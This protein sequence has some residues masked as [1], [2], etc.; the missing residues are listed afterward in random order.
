[1]QHQQ[2]P[3]AAG[4]F[5][6]LKPVAEQ[7]CA[8]PGQGLGVNLTINEYGAIIRTH[9]HAYSILEYEAMLRGGERNLVTEPV[10]LSQSS[11]LLHGKR[12]PEVLAREIV[13]KG[14]GGASFCAHGDFAAALALSRACPG[15]RV[16]LMVGTPKSTVKCACVV[17]ISP[18]PAPPS[19]DVK[20]CSF[21]GMSR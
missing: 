18:W 6:P 2:S 9:G 21:I 13:F 1:M 8:S 11:A 4:A 5:D 15:L 10:G 16:D 14:C 7:R 20:I 12:Q 19:N 3:S 17:H